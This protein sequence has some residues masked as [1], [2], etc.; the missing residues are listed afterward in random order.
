MPVYFSDFK[1]TRGSFDENQ[2]LDLKQVDKIGIGVLCP[3]GKE[4][5]ENE[6]LISDFCI[7]NQ[8]K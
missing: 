6:L 8:N 4:Q 7:L 3:H 2:N 1:L 5:S